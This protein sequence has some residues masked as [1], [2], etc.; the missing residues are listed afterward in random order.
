MKAKEEGKQL[1]IDAVCYTEVLFYYH[2]PRI[3]HAHLVLKGIHI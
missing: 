2:F 3:W 1:V